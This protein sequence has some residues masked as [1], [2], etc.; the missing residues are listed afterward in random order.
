M[1]AHISSACTPFF[2]KMNYTHSE[3][4]D[5]SGTNSLWAFVNNLMQNCCSILY[6]IFF[7]HPCSH[8]SNVHKLNPS[9]VES[10][11]LCPKPPPPSYLVEHVVR[12]LS[13]L[14]PNYPT[15]LQKIRR[16]ARPHHAEIVIELELRELPESSGTIKKGKSRAL[17]SYYK[18]K[19]NALIR[20]N[21]S[22]TWAARGIGSSHPRPDPS[23]RKMIHANIEAP[24]TSIARASSHIS[25]KPK[26][27]VQSLYDQQRNTDYKSE[28]RNYGPHLPF[29]PTANADTTPLIFSSLTDYYCHSALSLHFQ[30]S[31]VEGC[32]RL[33]SG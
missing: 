33:F 28:I 13:R 21:D 29:T 2:T 3:V 12:P 19:K 26:A 10:C 31:P 24:T 17:S 25:P 18:N 23:R 8:V 15:L 7:N 9:H 30:S 22:T 6:Y 32:S 5:T 27:D 11:R 20:T 16:A 4:L 1:L 14:V